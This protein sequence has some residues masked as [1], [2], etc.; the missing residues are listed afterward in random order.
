MLWCR[1]PIGV[2]N[3]RSV[4]FGA[5]LLAVTISMAAAK[6]PEEIWKG[7]LVEANIGWAKAHY[8]VLKIQDAAYLRDGDTSTLI[9]VKGKPD[10]YRWVKGTKTPGVLIAGVRAGH[11]FVVKDK[12]L[13]S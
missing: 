5:A 1:R 13:Y 8:A 6:T 11:P 9:G 12:R 4:I 7:E 3:V 2:L 10:S